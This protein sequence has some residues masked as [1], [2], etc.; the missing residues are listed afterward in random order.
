MKLLKVQN[1]MLDEADPEFLDL[2]QWM[3]G[4]SKTIFFQMVVKNGDFPL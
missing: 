3:L 4:I 2:L 1:M